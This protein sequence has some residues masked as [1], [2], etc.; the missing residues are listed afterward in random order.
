[1]GLVGKH[2]SSILKQSSK[3][4]GD[5]M[6]AEAHIRKVWAFFVF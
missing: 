4:A 5:C 2:I 1:M 3:I 6:L